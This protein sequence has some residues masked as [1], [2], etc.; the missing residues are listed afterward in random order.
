MIDTLIKNGI[1]LDGTGDKAVRCDIALKG[2]KII[3]VGKINSEAQKIIEKDTF[4][5]IF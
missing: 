3:E 4:K 5:K 1:V 2:D